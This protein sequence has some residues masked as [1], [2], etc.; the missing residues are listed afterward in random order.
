MRYP[1]TPIIANPIAQDVAI[2]LN[3]LKQINFNERKKKNLFYLV[4]CIYL[5][6]ECSHGRKFGSSRQFIWS[7]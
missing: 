5:K 3:S 1:T 7:L 6:I 4:C 2:F